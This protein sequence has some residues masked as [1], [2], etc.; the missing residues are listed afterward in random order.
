MGALY[1]W[2]AYCVIGTG[3][4][5]HI[6]R[7]SCGTSSSCIARITKRFADESTKKSPTCNGLF[8]Y[9]VDLIVV[10]FIAW[11]GV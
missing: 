4:F 11:G 2:V 9:V 5:E 1:F 3:L 8:N 7:K 6:C 10:N